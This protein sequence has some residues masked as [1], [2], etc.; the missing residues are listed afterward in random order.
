MQEL[1]MIEVAEVSGGGIFEDAFRTGL[2][3]GGL[4]NLYLYK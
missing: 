3:I 2:A 1:N 4:I